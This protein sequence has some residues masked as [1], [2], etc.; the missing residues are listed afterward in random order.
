MSTAARSMSRFNL[1]MT[2]A[3]ARPQRPS[4]AFTVFGTIAS[5]HFK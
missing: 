2:L 3:E 5:K 4:K 1:A